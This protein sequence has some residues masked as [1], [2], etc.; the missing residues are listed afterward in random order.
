MDLAGRRVLITGP[1]RGIGAAM[2]RELAARG[3]RLALV[4]LEPDAL[5]CLGDEL[6]AP[7]SGGKHVWV[8]ADVT[9]SVG[10]PAAVEQAAAVLGGFD[11]V[12]ANAGVLSLGIAA[13]MDPDV[14]AHVVEVNVTGVF[15]TVHAGLPYLLGS[16]GY[17]LLVSSTAAVFSP[18]SSAAYGASKSAVEALADALRIELARQGVAVGCAYLSWVDTDMLADAER[19]LPSFAGMRAS[20]PWPLRA[21]TPV[22]DCAVALVD[23][24]QARRARVGVPRGIGVARWLRPV[25]RSRVLDVLTTWRLSGVLARMEAEA[26][27]VA[28]ALPR[29]REASDSRRPR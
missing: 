21:T 16:G 7:A 2:A 24:I 3:A 5:A 9:D 20:L 22:A 26:S 10:L 13:G 6:P 4:G 25:L 29:P 17:V 8:E 14:F 15:R 18:V 28:R 12:V 11:V 27:R 1:A 19:D 23:A